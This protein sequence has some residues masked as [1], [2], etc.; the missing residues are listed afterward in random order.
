MA[1]AVIVITLLT[2]AASLASWLFSQWLARKARVSPGA[3][4]LGGGGAVLLIASV[5][6]VMAAAS[7]GWRQLMPVQAGY[8]RD[9]DML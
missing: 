7:T 4:A 2:L 3:L 6:F 8:S 5:A 9:D 1:T